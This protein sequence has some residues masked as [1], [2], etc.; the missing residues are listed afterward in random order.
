[1]E[2]EELDALVDRLIFH[3]YSNDS[4]ANI[5][6]PQSK[7]LRLMYE[8][9]L[10]DWVLLEEQLQI[11]LMHFYLHPQPTPKPC[12]DFD[13]EFMFNMPDADF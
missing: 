13:L 1:M 6:Y 3:V 7:I 4:K 12:A 5:C 2:H 9:L 8:A 10:S 11:I